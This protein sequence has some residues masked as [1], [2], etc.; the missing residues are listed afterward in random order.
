MHFNESTCRAKEL[1]RQ[2]TYI[3][4]NRVYGN[5]NGTMANKDCRRVF[6]RMVGAACHFSK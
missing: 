4:K 3:T 1:C 2:G 6:L 5:G